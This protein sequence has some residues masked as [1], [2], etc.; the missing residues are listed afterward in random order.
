MND[1]RAWDAALHAAP[2]ALGV[3][4]AAT[5]LVLAVARRARHL[6][7]P[8]ERSSHAVPTPR[9]GGLGIVAA[10]LVV[11]LAFP[12]AGLAPVPALAIACVV[13]LLD[14]ARGL[15]ALPKLAGTLLAAAA[16]L[17]F[18]VVAIAHDVPFAGGVALGLLAYPLTALW[19]ALYANAFNFMDG[20]DGIASLTAAVAGA[21][22]ALAGAR[23]GDEELAIWGAAVCGGSLGFLP[24]NFPRARIFLG[25]AGSLPL[26]LALAWCAVRANAT[27]ALAFPASMLLLGPFVF[28]VAF[29]L[30]RRWR[31]GKRFGEAHREHLYQRLARRLGSHVKVSLLYAGF[32]AATSCLALAYGSFGPLGKLLSLVLPGAAMLGFALLVLRAERARR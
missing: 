1:A 22:F 24:W 4:L 18:G 20:I 12:G 23:A 3:A 16:A 29:T 32:A 19:L 27:G 26:G 11:P 21:A 17:P 8:N 14:D 5:G 9:S 10:L 7:L 6:D 31:E 25:D 28:D 2:L 30:F 15:A 13:G